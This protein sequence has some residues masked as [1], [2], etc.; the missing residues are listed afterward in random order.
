MNL[1]PRERESAR[2]RRP[3]RSASPGPSRR[4][5]RGQRPCAPSSSTSVTS[6]RHGRLRLKAIAARGRANGTPALLARSRRARRSDA[7]RRRSRPAFTEYSSPD[8]ARL[9]RLAG[10]AW[11]AGLGRTW[12]R[13]ELGGVCGS[14]S[15]PP[16]LQP[17]AASSTAIAI[18]AGERLIRVHRRRR[19]PLLGPGLERR[20]KKPTAKSMTTRSRPS[21]IPPATCWSVSGD[22]PCSGARL[23]VGRR[24]R[25]FP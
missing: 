16:R 6:A 18:A 2:G 23:G 3:R 1:P 15:S 24:T 5:E 12:R 22:I 21:I 8:R 17:G 9:R 11:L 14:S 25:R 10:L 4:A 20:K 19:G 13:L 7:A